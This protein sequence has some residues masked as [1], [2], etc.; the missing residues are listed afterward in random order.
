MPMFHR[1]RSLVAI[2]FSAAI[3]LAQALVATPAAA[4][5]LASAFTYQ[6]RL[7]VDGPVP[8]EPVDLQFRLFDAATGGTQIGPTVSRPATALG[9]SGHFTVTLDFGSTAFGP[10]ARWLEVSAR[11]WPATGTPGGGGSG[12]WSGQSATME[13]S[14]TSWEPNDLFGFSATSAG[15]VDGDGVDDLVIGAPLSN[16]GGS[17]SGR[18]DIY[19]TQTG[20]LVR[21]IAGTAGQ[22]LGTSV[23]GLGDVDGDGTGD[24]AASGV[25]SQS[26]QQQD[27][28]YVYSGATGTILR[29]YTSGAGG[30][31]AVGGGVGGDDGFGALVRGLG[32][33]NGDGSPE[34]AIVASRRGTPGSSLRHAEIDIINTAT[35]GDQR[36]RLVLAEGQECVLDVN[37]VAIDGTY[38]LDV[39]TM[40]A[41]Q[42]YSH[43]LF[44]MSGLKDMT[45]T[46]SGDWRFKDVNKDNVIDQ[47]DV[48]LILDKLT[49]EVE[50]GSPFKFD[51]NKD[52]VFNAEDLVD[53]LSA[54]T[55]APILDELSAFAQNR[56]QEL[57]ERYPLYFGMTEKVDMSA[58]ELKVEEKREG[59]KECP[60]EQRKDCDNK[61]CGP[62]EWKV[63]RGGHGYPTR[64]GDGD[65]D[66]KIKLSDDHV[67]AFVSISCSETNLM[68]TSD[69]AITQAKATWSYSRSGI[70]EG[71]GPA[72]K[73][74]ISFSLT[75]NA[76][77]N[78]SVT[79]S[80][81]PGSKAASKAGGATNGVGPG[82]LQVNFPDPAL[83]AQ[84]EYV[85]GQIDANG[86]AAGRVSASGNIGPQQASAG[87]NY[88]GSYSTSVSWSLPNTGM[89]SGS[90]R[91]NV[92]PS[93]N[94]RYAR[95]CTAETWTKEWS[96]T[97]DVSGNGIAQSSSEGATVNYTADAESMITITGP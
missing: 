10:E 11:Q 92:I 23:A 14:V 83:T 30:A 18:I 12:V 90:A 36:L 8:P 93:A 51:V 71:S 35:I 34:V 20:Q 29:A 75:G 19:S 70:W 97:L 3:I 6:G 61:C 43:V 94:T 67:R 86:A 9:A 24:I 1:S 16:A 55:N 49:T 74:D 47:D 76:T 54:T 77:H 81:H 2:L 41:G 84:A 73:R 65:Y 53:V 96:G 62:G 58:A 4:A 21:S 15:D 32:D 78:V 91:Y 31:G 64:S 17:A 42:T 82:T 79:V 69:G 50:P 72:C 27:A 26:G 68:A 89:Q 5:P 88:S 44:D 87:A 38:Y 40:A 46:E 39:V 63:K 66:A 80:A 57:N 60:P 95:S 7:I 48:W 25:L 85:Q 52:G 13:L 33:L 59:C 45:A 37:V 22:V 56:I 28:V